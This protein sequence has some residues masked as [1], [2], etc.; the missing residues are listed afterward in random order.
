MCARACVQRITILLRNIMS[1][2]G[3]E[4]WPHP[5][6]SDNNIRRSV[7]A[8]L[9]EPKCVVGD[10]FPPNRDSSRDGLKADVH[11][12]SDL[13]AET[14]IYHFAAPRDPPPIMAVV[15]PRSRPRT[16]DQVFYVF[17]RSVSSPPAVT[18]IR[19]TA[20]YDYLCTVSMYSVFSLP[21]K[22]C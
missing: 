10:C 8:I 3:N 2:A 20:V 18:G 15:E 16:V 6:R 19:Y 4:P 12:V 7:F 9:A 22:R 5:Q 11:L 1:L 17:T 13:R 14:Q 21:N